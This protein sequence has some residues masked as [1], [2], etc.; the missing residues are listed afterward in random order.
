LLNP[1]FTPSTGT[2][3]SVSGAW[4]GLSLAT[5]QSVT[6]TL[7]GTVSPTATGSITNTVTVSPPSGVTDPNPNNNTAADTD[8]LT[9]QADLSI[10]KTNNVTSV[11]PGTTTTYT[12]TV[13]NAGP[14]TVNSVTV[15]DTLPGALL[16]PVFTPSTGSYNSVSGVWTGLS[17]A[18]G[19]SVTMTLTGTVS[20]T[21]TGSITNTVT[22]SPPSGVTDPNPN[23]NTAADTDPLTPTADLSIAKTNNVTSVVPGTTTTYTITVSNAGPSTVNSVTVVDTLPGA[24]LNPVFTPSTGSYNSVS[25][26]WT[27]LSLATGQSVTMTLTGT[28]S[29]TATGSITNTVTVSPPSGV[30]DPNSGNNTATDTDPLIPTADLSIAKTN[31]VTS[32]VPGTTT[33]YTITVSNAGP[34]TVNSVTV[35]DTL[36]GALLNPVFTPSTGS[37]NSVSGVWTGLSLATGQ[38][39]TMTLTGTVSPTATGSITNTVTV[40]PPSGVT[41]PNP[42]NNTAADTDPLTPQADLSIAKT[43]NVTSVVPGTTTTYTITVSNAGPSTVNSVTVVD[44]L[45]GALLNPVFTPSTGSYNSVSGVWT[46]LS[47]ATGQSVT[48]TLTGTVSPTA[49]GSI[50]NTVTVS[51]PSGVTDPNP[52]NNT[53]ADTD[54]LTP[55][56]DLSIAK[57]NNVTS[58]V[59]GT[60]TTY[61]ITVSNAG[62]STVNS[63]TVVDTLP[64]ALL[65]PV[66][67][68]STGSY[69][70]VSG[71]WTGLSLATGQ[72]VTMTLTGTV[73]PTA[74]GS[75]TNTVTVSPP[76]GVTDP[77][78]NNNTATDTDPLTPTADLSIAKTNNVTSVV[79]GTTTTYTITVSNA[80]PSTVSSVTVIDTLPG[81]LLNPV[82]TPSTGTYNSVSGAWTGLSLATGQSVTMTLTGTVS[83]TATG[84]ITNTVTVSPPSGV[85]DPN[86]GNNTAADTDPLTPTAD[87]SIAKTNNVTS[88]VPG[89]TTTYTITVSNAGP[90]TVSSVTVIDTLPAALLNPVFTP[91]TGSYNSV[92]GA[93]TGLSL[94]T[95]QS[96]TMTLTGT[97]SPTATGSITNTVT[98]SPP[99]GVTDPNPNN[100]TATDTDPLTPTADLSIAKTNNVTSVVPGTTTTYTITVSNAGPSTVNSVTVVDTLPGALLNPVFTPSTG[101]YNSVSGV[102]TGLSLATGQSVTMTLTGTV[103]PTATGSI[104]N[105]VTVSPPSG[106][107]DPNPNNNTAADTDPL[108]PQADLSIAKTNNVTS[109]VPGTTTTYTI[110]VSNAGPSTVNSVTVVDT[111]PGPC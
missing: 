102:W 67:T 108:T 20:P 96:V 13:S 68:P 78:P 93:W 69:N 86:S 74:T 105:T 79:P 9:P 28:V 42:N 62:P 38:S 106:V 92:S 88:V 57:T 26:V 25:G 10:A 90:S 66:F 4:T 46:G 82:F 50:T 63:V 97:V 14:S 41:D 64:G 40:S 95:G 94:A 44:T 5:G 76:S 35:V 75:I 6:M 71:V 22:V 32:V 21:A 73:S 8:P 72:S 100:N 55:Q 99:S 48:M 24:L 23:N 43:N 33:T 52:N 104:T 109:V 31:N 56:A 98:V 37:Y 111:L 83:P 27:G 3:N 1:V 103:S 7:T 53:A 58:V 17:L 15:V 70:S 77:N 107:T 91:S 61:T 39:V 49:T 2:Y 51:P 81:A 45:P 29:P 19:Q 80:G 60:T 54:P 85:T 18:T 89:T 59:P 16:N 12:I 30:T 84:S 34:S 110:T 47:L 87:L 36:P 65:N 101:S 11:V